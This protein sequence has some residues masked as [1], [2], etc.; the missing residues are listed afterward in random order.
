MARLDK[1]W[2]DRVF[3]EEEARQMREANWRIR[4]DDHISG[5]VSLVLRVET[6]SGNVTTRQEDTTAV[7]SSGA[8]LLRPSE[9]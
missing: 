7:V 2:S 4:R 9:H 5:H 1:I 3:S 8:G 6:V